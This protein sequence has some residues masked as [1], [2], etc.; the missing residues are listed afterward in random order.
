MSKSKKRAKR[1]AA[2]TLTMA[3][4]PMVDDLSAVTVFVSRKGKVIGRIHGARPRDMRGT[5]GDEN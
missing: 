2:L 5:H 4:L 3:T 1:L